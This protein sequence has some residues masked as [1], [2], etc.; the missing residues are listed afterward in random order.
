MRSH[1]MST[2]RIEMFILNKIVS[3]K[4][5][6]PCIFFNIIFFK[7]CDRKNIRL[8]SIFIGLVFYS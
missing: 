4:F 1:N 8:K 7:T 5:I 2:N 3:L 6:D